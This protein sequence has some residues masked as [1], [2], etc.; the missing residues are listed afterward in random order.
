MLHGFGAGCFRL[1][2]EGRGADLPGVR[3]TLWGAFNAVGE[4]LS[5]ERG[6]STDAR[7]NSLWFGASARTNAGALEAALEMAG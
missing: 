2:E 3:G 1:H 5:Y 7:L 6:G 4:Y